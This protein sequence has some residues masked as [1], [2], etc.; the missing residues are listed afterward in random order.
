MSQDPKSPS[1]FPTGQISDWVFDLD[2]T[3]YPAKSNLF[4]RVAVRITEFVARHF[5]VPD[6]EARVIQKDLFQRYGTT[7]RG[8][9]VEQNLAPE[10]F[11]HFVHDIDVSDLPFEAELDA[12][13]TA[14]PGRKHIFTN[15]TVP[16]AENILNAYGIRHHFDHIFDIVGA[17]FVPKPEKQAFDRFMQVTDIDPAGAVMIEDMAR[18]LEPAHHLGMR[19]VWLA[20]DHDWAQRG[21]DE[22]YV[23]F[24]AEDL[25]SFLSALA[26]QD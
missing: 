18:N 15:G 16:H 20:S 19:T 7:M 21:A 9:M 23:H 14:L 24:V 2:N 3:I 8:L 13:L 6:D 11:L 25:K 10:A 1:T 4:V 26:I 17:D 5:D 12:M 22:D